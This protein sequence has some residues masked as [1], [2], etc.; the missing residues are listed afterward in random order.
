MDAGYTINVDPARDLL[1]FTLTGFFAPEDV[2]RFAADKKAAYARLTC[3][4]NGH[5]TLVDV[6]D[7]KIQ[8]QSVVDAFRQV[9][10]DPNHQARRL[11]FVTGSSLARMQVR[12]LAEHRALRYFEDRASARVWLFSAEAEAA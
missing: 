4:R 7:C 1:E 5:L 3:P 10:A 12:R 9:L 2:A 8:P 11:A 6:S